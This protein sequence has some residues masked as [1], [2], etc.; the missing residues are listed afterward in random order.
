MSITILE[1]LER[2]GVTLN[3]NQL[4]SLGSRIINKH[5]RFYLKHG[6]RGTSTVRL[7][8]DVPEFHDEVLKE[9]KSLRFCKK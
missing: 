8:R 2:A 7:Y 3:R 1:A 4:S 5:S 6:K 9:C